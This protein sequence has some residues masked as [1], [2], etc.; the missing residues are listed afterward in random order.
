MSGYDADV[1][2]D[3]ELEH[4][5]EPMKKLEHKG[6]IC[7]RCCVERGAEGEVWCLGCLRAEE[8]VGWDGS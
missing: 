5:E 7:S 1:K 2:N 8:A 3:H 6:M 4:L